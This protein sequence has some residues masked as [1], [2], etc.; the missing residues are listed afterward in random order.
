MTMTA[1]M[2]T[3]KDIRLPGLVETLL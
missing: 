3:L 2:A 1:L